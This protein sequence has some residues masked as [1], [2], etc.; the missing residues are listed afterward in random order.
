VARRG[1]SSEVARRGLSSACGG[2]GPVAIMFP[3]QGAQYVG[4]ADKYLTCDA[5][6][7]VFTV[8]RDILGYDLL[9]LCTKGP[10]N[11]LKLTYYCQPAVMATSLAALLHLQHNEPQ[12]LERCVAAAGFSMGE[13]TALTFSGALS[14][15]DAFSVVRVRAKAM[16]DAS[17][18][19]PSGMVNIRG[20]GI[21]KIEEI[22]LAAEDECMK[23][24]EEGVAVIGNYL[25]PNCVSVSGSNNCLSLVAEQAANAGAKVRKLKVAGAFHSPLMSNASEALRRVLAGIPVSDPNIPVYNNITGTA[26]TDPVQLKDLFSQQLQMPVRWQTLIENIARDHDNDLTFYEVGPSRQIS[27]MIQQIDRSYRGK[28]FATD[29]RGAGRK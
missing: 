28:I 2:D 3:G 27:A 13:L 23:D 20:L 17:I 24:G 22:C 14:L 21:D 15:D 16:H 29:D 12:I 1:L 18:H 19:P 5:S 26:Y 7:E 10:E 9:K 8:A 25:F 4:M 6:R 11:V